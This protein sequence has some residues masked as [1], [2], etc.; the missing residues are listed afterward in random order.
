[1][2]SHAPSGYQ[3]PFCRLVRGDADELNSPRFVV[4]E[5]DVTLAFV[6]PKWWP[7]NPGHVLV[8]PK[9][10][11]ENIYAMPDTLLS[12]VYTVSKRMAVAMREAYRCEGTSTRQHNEPGGGQDVWH[13][14]VHVF[15]RYLGDKLYTN[16]GSSRWVTPDERIV[17]VDKL[18]DYFAVS[19]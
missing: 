6:A 4:Y 13:F 9:A 18:R 2:H 12:H 11:H 7:N 1:M 10:H 17:Y 8:I 3:C 5:D 15:P 14:H 19:Q 16:N